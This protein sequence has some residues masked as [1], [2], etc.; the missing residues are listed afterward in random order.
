MPWM[1]GLNYAGYGRLSAGPKAGY[2]LAH[3]VAWELKHGGVPDGFFVLHHCDNP[4]CV[5]V[6]HLFLGDHSI[7]MR[8]KIAKGRGAK[9]ERI[10][11]SKLAESEVR[12]IRERYAK[13]G[14][15]Q[16]QL[17][18]AYGV[19]QGCISRVL[20]GKDWRHVIA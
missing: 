11:Q 4:R 14:I 16:Y 12:E 1:G 19:T 9:G 20:S 18:K 15:D 5:N 8:D 17:A 10:A 3:R 2:I 6:D 7:N 13:G